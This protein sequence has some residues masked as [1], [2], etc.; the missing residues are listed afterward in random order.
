MQALTSI[1]KLD[2]AY[3]L[4]VTTEI[5]HTGKTFFLYL[6]K[7]MTSPEDNALISP[8]AKVREIVFGLGI[9]LSR[10]ILQLHNI[11]GKRKENDEVLHQH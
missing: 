1:C 7:I 2:L 5:F 8:D 3:L 6:C 10:V 9:F 11:D 4:S